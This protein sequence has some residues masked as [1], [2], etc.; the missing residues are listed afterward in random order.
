[1][2]NEQE[3]TREDTH[4]EYGVA[5]CGVLG[6][7]AAMRVWTGAF[8]ERSPQGSSERPIRTVGEENNAKRPAGESE[9]STPV[10]VESDV[11]LK[12]ARGWK[13]LIW[14]PYR[15]PVLNQDWTKVAQGCCCPSSN[16]SDQELRTDPERHRRGQPQLLSTQIHIK[17]ITPDRS[18]PGCKH[19]F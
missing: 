14:R 5:Q 4:G 16:A 2:C 17:A 10:V 3:T 13:A 9:D 6:V 8:L 18:F 7:W 12:N 19:S 15:V 11:K 1:V